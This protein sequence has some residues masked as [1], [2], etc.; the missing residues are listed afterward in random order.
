MN[1]VYIDPGLINYAGHHTSFCR[2]LTRA[3]RQHGHTVSIYGNRYM[4]DSIRRDLNAT[5]VFRANPYTEYVP[6][7][8]T[9][10]DPICGWLKA[11]E[12]I[13][14]ATLE[15][16]GFVKEPSPDDLIYWN[17]AFPPQLV[18]LTHWLKRLPDARR[19]KVILELNL[20]SGIEAGR[21]EEGKLQFQVPDP[22]LKQRPTLWRYAALLLN[23]PGLRDRI[24]LINYE[25][26]TIAGYEYLMK[27]PVEAWVPPFAGLEAAH[28]RVGKRAFAIGILG[29]QREEKGFKL[30]PE[31]VKRLLDA[32]RDIA[33]LVHN[34]DPAFMADVQAELRKMAS[35]FDRLVLREGPLAPGGWERTLASCDLI[36]CPYDPVAFETRCSGMLNEAIANAIPVVVP[37]KTSLSRMLEDFGSPG[38]VFESWSACSVAA[39][40]NT[41]LD[42]Y[43]GHAQ[44]AFDA[45]VRWRQEHSVD[46]LVEKM[47]GWA[48]ASRNEP[49]LAAADA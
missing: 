4:V 40:V 24:K 14:Q 21:D 13:W 33:I 46:Q 39:A 11:F 9:E 44:S 29:Y 35:C 31:L 25:A 48:V 47:T 17:S 19:P 7:H 23:D 45:S 22:R 36:L 26:T 2:H 5:P 34:C 6:E 38:A 49:V 15:D 32:R 28:S 16:L 12:I 27:Q 10:A 18:A 30:V 1:F 37:A 8:H 43:D 3:L 41:V 20:D 42:A